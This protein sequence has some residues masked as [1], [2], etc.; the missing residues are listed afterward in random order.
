VDYLTSIVRAAGQAADTL[1]CEF[2]SKKPVY[3]EF[4]LNKQGCRLGFFL[5]PRVSAE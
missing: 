5:A 1:T 4:R 2:S 3:L